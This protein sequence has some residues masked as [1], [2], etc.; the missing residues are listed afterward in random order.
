MLSAFIRRVRCIASV[1]TSSRELRPRLLLLPLSALRACLEVERLPRG[2]RAGGW[3]ATCLQGG[4]IRGRGSVTASPPLLLPHTLRARGRSTLRCRQR[5][6]RR[7]SGR[8]RSLAH[9][10][11][12]G[13]AAL[14][15][16]GGGGAH[17]EHVALV[18]G[19]VR[20]QA[21][22]P[23]PI[24]VRRRGCRRVAA[25][26]ARRRR[27]QIE[28]TGRSHEAAAVRNALARGPERA[29]QG[30]ERV[31]QHARVPAVVSHD[32]ERAARAQRGRS[33]PQHSPVEHVGTLG[34][35]RAARTSRRLLRRLWVVHIDGN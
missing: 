21:R 3:F 9:R 27:D 24:E 23:Q 32:S 22:L 15:R 11:S 13:L 10:V 31:E 16:C 20:R 5:G 29:A 1:S 19:G 25:P 2:G 35:G 26:L 34:H 28:A 7:R 8:L 12:C 14:G 18:R 6:G 4:F 33:G 17:V 30:G